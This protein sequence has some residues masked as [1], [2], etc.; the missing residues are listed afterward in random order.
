MK[1]QKQNVRLICHNILSDCLINKR[2]LEASINTEFSKYQLSD[3]DKRFAYEIC[4]GTVR[5]KLKLEWIAVTTAK[6]NIDEIEPDLLILLILSIYQLLYMD[7]VP[8]RAVVHEG[9][10]LCKKLNKFKAK[11]FINAVLR[12]VSRQINFYRKIEKR[13]LNEEY[14]Y[15]LLSYPQWLAEKWKERFGIERAA[16]IM[17]ASNHPGPVTIRVNKLKIEGSFDDFSSLMLKNYHLKMI[18]RPL[19]GCYHLASFA[20]INESQEFSDGKLY[21]QDEVSQM[22]SYVLQ[23]EENDRILDCCSAPGGKLTHIYE[24]ANGKADIVA[25]DKSD[26]KIKLIEENLSRLG[27]TGVEV[28]KG[29]A[30]EF[31]SK[32]KFDKILIDAPC[33]GLGI[34]RRYPDIKWKR[35]KEDFTSLS[36]IQFA[37]LDNCSK[38]L[39]KGGYLVYSVCSFE[40]EETSKVIEDFLKKSNKNGKNKFELCDILDIVPP[41]YRKTFIN[42]DWFWS[43]PES[44]EGMDGFFIAKLKKLI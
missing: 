38:L 12:G 6:R 35:T 11:N 19:G 43:I 25:I 18:R 2:D 8:P 9:V 5:W 7:K 26:D 21:I 1:D 34:V 32:K 14:Y 23:P 29:D 33:S 16:R 20:N 36:T 24:L 13:S 3:R 41:A 17:Y 15:A 37:I 22:A 31:K 28:I 39:K 44:Q 27:V 4:L 30:S 10:E 40:E 42:N